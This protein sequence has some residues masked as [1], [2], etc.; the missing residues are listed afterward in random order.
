VTLLQVGAGRVVERSELKQPQV[1][2][3]RMAQKAPRASE[4]V[5]ACSMFLRTGS[6]VAAEPLEMEATE[7][8]ALA[9]VVTLVE[10]LLPGQLAGQVN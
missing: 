2:P 10:Q 9:G 7:Q 8:R 3:D 6:A 1:T 4:L 5:L